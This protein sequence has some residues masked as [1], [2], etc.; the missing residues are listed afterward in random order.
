MLLFRVS[1][2]HRSLSSQPLKVQ[3]QYSTDLHS[4]LSSCSLDKPTPKKLLPENLALSATN[5]DE[6]ATGKSHQLRRRHRF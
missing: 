4:W 2:F 6:T 3:L 5:T 1:H